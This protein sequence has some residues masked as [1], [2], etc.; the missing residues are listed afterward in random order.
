MSTVNAQRTN[1]TF[2]RNTVRSSR[3]N[4]R[5]RPRF[6]C[7]ECKLVN[8]CDCLDANRLVDLIAPLL[9]QVL[10]HL[11]TDGSFI[12]GEVCERLA[13]LADRN[14]QREREQAAWPELGDA[15][16]LK[17]DRVLVED[18]VG[19]WGYEPSHLRTPE[20]IAALRKVPVEHVRGLL[21][22]F[23]RESQPVPASPLT[24]VVEM[25]GRAFHEATASRRAA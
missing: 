16:D 4:P 5:P 18:L 15:E 10:S 17:C 24:N 20:G 8:D 12:D 7:A 1:P 9:R 6:Q 2:S 13:L 23:L 25:F 14:D 22:R 3:K 11:A 19:P 21:D